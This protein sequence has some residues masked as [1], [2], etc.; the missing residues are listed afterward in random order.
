MR[1]HFVFLILLFSTISVVAQQKDLVDQIA[2]LEREGLLETWKPKAREGDPIAQRKLGL[3]YLYGK[4]EDRD[5]T[6]GKYWLEDAAKAGDTESMFA[7]GNLFYFGTDGI[8]SDHQIAMSWYEKA[9]F[10]G[11]SKATIMRSRLGRGIDEFRWLLLAAE[12]GDDYAQYEVGKTYYLGDRTRRDDA[13]AAKWFQM[14]A[15]KNNVGAIYFLGLMYRFG[16]A[17]PQDYKTAFTL[18]ATAAEKGHRDARYELG[19]C[20]AEGE[21]S[22]TNHEGAYVIFRSLAREMH[23]DSLNQ[24]AMFYL[25]GLAVKRNPTIAYA[26]LNFIATKFPGAPSVVDRR[27]KIRS[28]LRESEV[29][30]GQALT[31]KMLEADDFI[32][33]IDE[34]ADQNKNPKTKKATPRVVM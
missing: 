26:F 29:E 21:G 30:V 3:L 17:V 19:R 32:A 24:L 9:A 18:F 7:L 23:F 31:K 25:N 14:A 28:Q 27:S 13:A 20:Y 8:K 5:A 1:N 10:R 34:F 22:R 4:E 11:V 2:D 16:Q 6:L 12:Q 33:V 15:Q